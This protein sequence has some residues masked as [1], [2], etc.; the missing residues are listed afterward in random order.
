MTE[1]E[2]V[3]AKLEKLKAVVLSQDDRNIYVIYNQRGKTKL[4]SF[5]LKG[6]YYDR[7]GPNVLATFSGKN[8]WYKSCSIGQSLPVWF[9]D[10]MEIMFDNESELKAFDPT[11]LGDLKS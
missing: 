9:W 4:A 10:E 3:K 5:E 8:F 7:Y 2:Q 1:A 11:I 6:Y